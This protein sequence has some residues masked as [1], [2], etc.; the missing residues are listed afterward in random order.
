MIENTNQTV[1]DQ[2]NE[3]RIA[4]GADGETVSE[5]T[6]RT[7][8]YAANAEDTPKRTAA[9]KKVLFI[10]LLAAIALGGIAFCTMRRTAPNKA[11]SLEPVPV[12]SP[13]DSTQIVE[14]L[15]PPQAP[16][17]LPTPGDPTLGG[18][19]NPAANNP[20]GSFQ[21]GGG[22]DANSP[23]TTRPPQVVQATT[24][25]APGQQNS[26]NGGSSG[27]NPGGSSGS[28][29][30]GGNSGGG[31]GNN[32][33]APKIDQDRPTSKT[34]ADTKAIFFRSSRNS[35][36]TRTVSRSI[37]PNSDGFRET[38]EA[39]AVKRVPFGTQLPLRTLGAVHSLLRNSLARFELTR[40]VRGNGWYLPAGTVIVAKQTQAAGNRM[41]FSPE[42]FIYKNRFYP[43]QGE[44]SGIDGA[45]G[46]KGDRKQI[47][48][49]W[50][51][52]ALDLASRAQ[53]TLNAWLAG[54]G[55]GN[56][57]STSIQIPDTGGLINPN[58]SNVVK[59]VVVPPMTEGYLLVTYLP[60]SAADRNL[61]DEISSEPEIA[62]GIKLEQVENA[63]G[64]GDPNQIQRLL[65]P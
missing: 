40:E 47:G 25:N 53:S 57:T 52:V 56:I 55:G 24:T 28:S 15:V 11:V 51:K 50:Y 5:T 27:G 35:P 62:P 13:S 54:R 34:A 58:Q 17:P 23:V 4:E 60:D 26:S 22:I 45:A 20:S 29:S 41:F 7:T 14:N 59:Y 8:V 10:F 46:L 30:G 49:K 31:G 37:L 2:I 33:S 9:W 43:L 1:A 19:V 64:S 3:T 39:E 61:P 32:N 36:A 38:R 48:S 12:K 42:G 21:M 16:T 18:I 63:L 44:V 6:D 65:R